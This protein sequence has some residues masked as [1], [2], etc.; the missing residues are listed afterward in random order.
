MR[1]IAA[2]MA[3]VALAGGALADEEAPRTVLL[4]HRFAAGETLKFR[5]RV[6]GAGSITMMDQPQAVKI[7]GRFD[8]AQKVLQVGDDGA[9]RILTTVQGGSL[10]FRF[11]ALDVTQTLPISLP[12]LIQII[13][14]DGRLLKSPGWQGEAPQTSR[15]HINLRRVIERIYLLRFPADPIAVGHS[16]VQAPPPVAAPAPAA[17]PETAP[18]EPA[19]A[20]EPAALPA[21]TWKLTFTGLTQVAGQECARIRATAES[22]VKAMLPPDR[23]GDVIELDGSERLETI[24]DFAPAAGRVVRQV[25]SARTDLRTLTHRAAA[26]EPLTGETHIA[27]KVTL[28]ARRSA[29]GEGGPAEPPAEEH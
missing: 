28:E 24:T 8:L 6:D 5:G 11:V 16:W 12:P 20:D 18:S 3:L 7:E 2:A 13:T 21:P 26:G 23:M 27:A 10:A 15:A 4:R 1:R 29:E 9:A 22:P 14:P 17:E 25:A 19:P